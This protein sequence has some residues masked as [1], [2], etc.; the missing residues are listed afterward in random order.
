MLVRKVVR[1]VFYLQDALADAASVALTIE[2][3]VPYMMSSMT[4]DEKKAMGFQP[5]ENIIKCIYD[6][7]Q[8]NSTR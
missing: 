8:C 3:S 1:S 5:S 6:H 4:T 7:K 2:D